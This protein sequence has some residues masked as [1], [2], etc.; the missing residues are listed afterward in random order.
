VKTLVHDGLAAEGPRNLLG[1]GFAAEKWRSP[2]SEFGGQSLYQA[3]GERIHGELLK[4]GLEISERRV[5]RLMP[6]YRKAPSQ[7]WRAFLTHHRR[8]VVHCN[9]TEP[10]HG[11]MDR[12]T[13][14]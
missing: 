8:R 10:S 1:Q 14:G 7:T 5:F 4:L 9:V 2:A 12:T 11:W 3:D 13:D 6:K